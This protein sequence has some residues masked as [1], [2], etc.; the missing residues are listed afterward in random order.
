MLIDTS[1]I[2]QLRV[3]FVAHFSTDNDVIEATNQIQS[4]IDSY[5][6]E[7]TVEIRQWL[8]EQQ[9]SR[10]TAPLATIDTS[11][12]IDDFQDYLTELESN[13]KRFEQNPKS[14]LKFQ[15]KKTQLT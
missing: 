4:I 12:S 2:E 5:P 6:R 8:N 10:L 14:D 7:S 3:N 9:T 1:K 15:V 11:K 13:L